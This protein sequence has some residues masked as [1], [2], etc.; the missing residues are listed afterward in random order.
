MLID[1]SSL[2]KGNLRGYF[3]ILFFR[4]AHICTNMKWKIYVFFPIWISY[5][6]LCNI[7][8]GID[9]HEKTTIGRNLV[10]WHGQ[11]LIVHP[12]TIIGNDVTLHHNT[13]IGNKYPGGRAPVIK[14][15]VT[16]GANCVII[17]N[18]TIGSYCEI[19]AGAVVTKDIPEKAIVVGNPAKIIKYRNI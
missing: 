14:D 18:I 15:G 11:G 3:F 8:L 10:I 5:R 1:D 19:G 16:I 7:I 6:L 2:Y 12:K 13:T 17:G 9:I 4:L